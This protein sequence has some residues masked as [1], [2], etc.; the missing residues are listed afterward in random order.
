MVI[1][2]KQPGS[3]TTVQDP[4]RYGFQGQGI[5]VS[6]VM[7]PMAIRRANLLVGNPPDHPVFECIGLGPVLEFTDAVFFAVCGGRF[8][9][10][11]N[12][13]PIETDRL[14][15]ARK[16]DVLKITYSPS[17]R[18]CVVA[19]G[20]DFT[21]LPVYGSYASDI[22]SSIGPVPRKLKAMETIELVNVRTRLPNT[23][24][25]FLDPYPEKQEI[26]QL[27]VIGGPNEE[28]FTEEGIAA[29]YS[30]VYRISAKSDRMGFRLDGQIPETVRGN[31]ILSAGIVTGAVQ[32]TPSQPILMMADHAATGGYAVIASVITA[33][34]PLASQ[35]MPSDAVRFV[36]VSVEE[37]QKALS[38][39][40]A[41]LAEKKKEFA[42][43]G[44]FRLPGRGGRR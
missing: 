28:S 4:G 26:T 16:D 32:V 43:N 30:S 2:V 37:A 31:D 13:I 44:F 34:L 42:G 19:F 11:L 36:R 29:F 14:Y 15:R 41:Y 12:D 38:E 24:R 6:G 40:N 33:D 25:R 8:N 18:S 9:L 5:P 10:F 3:L 17:Y 22:K 35:L 1:K 39:Q 20:A 21:Y 7:D 23:A 27:R